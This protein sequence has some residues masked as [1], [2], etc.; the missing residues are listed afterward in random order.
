MKRLTSSLTRKLWLTIIAAIVVTILYSYFLSYF[1]YEKLYVENVETALLEEGR[2]LALEYEGGPLSD[3]LKERIDWYSSKSETEIFI[4]N[5]PRELS[6]CLPFDIDYESLISGEER[7]DLLAGKAVQKLGYEERFDRKIMAVVIP[8]LDENRLEGIIYLY[9]PLTKISEVT[10]DFAYLWLIAAILFLVLAIFL[11]TFLVRK[12]TKPLLEMKHAAGMVSK[13]D[14]S[15]RINNHSK[16]EVGQLALAF[17]HM[18]TSIQKEDERKKE[19]LANVS[20]ELRTPVSYVKGYSN[21][22]LTGIANSEDASKHLMLIYREAGRMERLV[23]DLLDLSRL[24]S[25]DYQII[26]HP[27]PL[28]QL[29]E[30]AIQKYLPKIKEKNLQFRYELDPDIIINGDEGRLEQ[31]LQNILDNAI[32]YTE[33]GSIHLKLFAIEKGCCIEIVDSGIGIPAD[34]LDKIK[35]RFYRV[36]KARTRKD[37]GTG[38]GLAIAEQLVI[39]HGGSLIINSTIGKGTTIQ[40]HLPVLE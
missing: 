19:F 4:V 9:I 6:A 40:I 17:N 25:D 5:N 24:D 39:L 18:A 1:F 34:H 15:V 20:H 10:T 32:C 37:G 8:L 26:M 12:L 23:G 13:G 33:K 21:A 22:L 30:D 11:G 38:L 16:D 14:Y 28:A 29:I 27:L 31:V 36:N 2:R 7:E 35:Q 3:D